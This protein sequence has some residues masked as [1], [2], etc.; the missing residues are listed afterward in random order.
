MHVYL[1]VFVFWLN[2]GDTC[3]ETVVDIFDGV[4][5]LLGEDMFYKVAF[6]L[7]GWES[8]LMEEQILVNLSDL[9]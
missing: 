1:V 5:F 8:I 9:E 3:T 7:M 2:N 4:T 6:M